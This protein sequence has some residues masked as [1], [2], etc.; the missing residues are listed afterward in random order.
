MNWI[1]KWE[2]SVAP[3]KREFE[4]LLSDVLVV[5]TAEETAQA[6]YEENSIGYMGLRVVRASWW[7]KSWQ[8]DE[9]RERRSMRLVI[10]DTSIANR[11]IDNGLGLRSTRIRI[12]RFQ[13]KGGKQL[14][15]YFYE[16]ELSASFFTILSS[17]EEM[18]V[19]GQE[20]LHY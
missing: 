12:K 2:P 15:L 16:S 17:Q 13:P 14:P 9:K 19:E 7:G 8:D 11:L 6:I 5:G 20:R 10:D 18:E 1:P 4:L 3:A